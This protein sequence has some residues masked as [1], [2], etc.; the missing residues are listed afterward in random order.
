MEVIRDELLAVREQYGDERRTEISMSSAEI[1][2]E[3]LITPGRRGR[4]LVS[5]GLC[6]VSAALRTTRPN[7]AVVV[8][9]RP[10]GSRKRTLWSVCWWPTPTTPFCASPPVARSTGSGCIQ[11]PGGVP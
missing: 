1:N 9:S 10:P 5:P 2:I 7:A 6:E 3:D 11:L 8:A 4:Y